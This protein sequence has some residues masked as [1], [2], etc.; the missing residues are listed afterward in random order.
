[1]RILPL[2]VTIAA[3]IVSQIACNP[4]EHFSTYKIFLSLQEI[5][6]LKEGASVISHNK[7]VGNVEEIEFLEQED[8]DRFIGTLRVKN[9]F[10]I[11][12]N[13]EIRIVSDIETS[14]AYVEIIPSHTR[15]SYVRGDTISAKGNIVQNKDL[16][17]EEVEIENLDSLPEGIRIL[18]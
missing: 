8:N 13:S 18:M 7:E 2:L 15:R 12:I 3:I 9:D 14:S 5:N 11:P 17:L 16:Q 6:E 4:I 10:L 1:M